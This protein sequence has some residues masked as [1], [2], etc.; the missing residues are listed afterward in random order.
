MRRIE[1]FM[2]L[3]YEVTIL[4][5]RQPGQD[6]FSMDC[7]TMTR[8]RV[9][10][11]VCTWSAAQAGG[12]SGQLYTGCGSLWEGSGVSAYNLYGGNEGKK[13]LQIS[14][15]GCP[16][17]GALGNSAGI[18]SL[19]GDE[20]EKRKPAIPGGSRAAADGQFLGDQENTL[21]AVQERSGG[22]RWNTGRGEENTSGDGGQDEDGN[23]NLEGEGGERWRA[24]WKKKS[25]G[26]ATKRDEERGGTETG[27]LQ[28]EAQGQ[29]QETRRGET[30]TENLGVETQSRRP[31]T[32]KWE[33]RG[34]RAP[35]VETQGVR[36]R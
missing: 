12:A 15:S 36:G 1:R 29:K 26:W 18:S 24:G 5:E 6:I 19:W 34:Q 25:G 32:R 22:W 16:G 7:T 8:R 13:S 3:E 30:E 4:Q 23:G 14:G 11:R 31:G 17:D 20:K 35:G 21:P 27:N 2:E 9:V 33:E 28:V 10:K